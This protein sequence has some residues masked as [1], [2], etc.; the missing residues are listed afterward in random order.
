M[1]T[2]RVRNQLALFIV[3]APRSTADVERIATTLG[4]PVTTPDD[5]GSIYADC[6][7]V[8]TGPLREVN[9]WRTKATTQNLLTCVLSLSGHNRCVADLSSWPR[10]AGTAITEARRRVGHLTA[11]DLPP[12]LS[13]SV[14]DLTDPICHDCQRAILDPHDPEVCIVVP[15]H[16]NKPSRLCLAH[17]DCDAVAHVST[18]QS[19]VPD[20]LPSKKETTRSSGGTEPER[21]RDPRPLDATLFDP[22]PS[23]SRSTENNQPQRSA[24][25]HANRRADASD[26][27]LLKAWQATED[28]ACCRRCPLCG[29]DVRDRVG[30]HLHASGG[31]NTVG[32]PALANWV[33]QH[34][35][36]HLDNGWLTDELRATQNIL[37]N[38]PFR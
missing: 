11:D 13:S 6:S 16:G 19:D 35:R 8:I 33:R 23:A 31:H 25:A 12:L 32:R 30:W 20:S 38:L 5:L 10:M 27:E 3:C 17:S 14:R 4:Q 29:C 22:R 34:F 7:V 21:A 28:G 15:P 9:R 18:P 36:T 24:H 26:L 37:N 2:T 1:T